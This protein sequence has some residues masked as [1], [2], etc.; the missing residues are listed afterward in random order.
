MEVCEK[1]WASQVAQWVKSLLVMQETQKMRVR[2]QRQE[3]FPEEGMA[4]HASIL[5]EGIPR[6]EELGGLQSIGQQRVRHD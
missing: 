6:T 2:S 1:R 3:D 4:T 5:A